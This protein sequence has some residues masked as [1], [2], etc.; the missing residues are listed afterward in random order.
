MVTFWAN[1]NVHKIYERKVTFVI[2]IN[3]EQIDMWH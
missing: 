1:F 2:Y 3:W